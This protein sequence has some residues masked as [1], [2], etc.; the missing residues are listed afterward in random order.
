MKS[1][2]KEDKNMIEE[3]K[4]YRTSDEKVFDD[5]KMAE[6]HELELQ[7]IKVYCVHYRPDLNEGR[8]HLERGYVFIH[9]NK[10]HEK[11]LKDWLHKKFG[12]PI[13]FVMGVYGS[14]AIMDSYTWYEVTE[15]D[16]KSDKV[17]ARIEENF[18]N[19]IWK[20]NK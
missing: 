15:S 3:I 8:G 20:E 13:S 12:N 7:K 4:T 10:Y 19:K 14:N 18:V 9:A 11:F 1:V 2:F 6:M 17:L 5:K 16:V